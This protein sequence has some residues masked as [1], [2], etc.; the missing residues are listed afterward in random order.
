MVTVPPPPHKLLHVF[1]AYFYESLL[2]IVFSVT[3]NIFCI[4]VISFQGGIRLLKSFQKKSCVS[5]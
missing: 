5:D 3:E 1:L 4:L 2:D